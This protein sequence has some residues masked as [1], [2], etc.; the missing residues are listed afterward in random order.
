[1]ARTMY[2]LYT[3]P[4]VVHVIHGGEAVGTEPN[5]SDLQVQDQIR[6]LNE[7]FGRKPGTNGC[8]INP[9]GA[10]TRIQF[11]LAAR[12]TN[13]N[14]SNGIT[15]HDWHT[16]SGA[17]DPNLAGTPGALQTLFN[18]KIKPATYWNSDEYMNIWTAKM[19]A[20]G[21]LGYAQFPSSGLPGLEIG[22]GPATFC[23]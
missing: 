22:P 14:A 20:S 21:L 13:G 4:V 1:T 3:I 16:I 5:I 8:N 6:I 15:R 12:D 2:D 23:N 17:T 7:D 11:V 9:V 10:D 19:N 18:S